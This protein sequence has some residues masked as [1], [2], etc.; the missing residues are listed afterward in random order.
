MENTGGVHQWKTLPCGYNPSKL[1]PSK[2]FF[3]KQTS[4]SNLENFSFSPFSPVDHGL[5]VNPLHISRSQIPEVATPTEIISSPSHSVFTNNI[6][7]SPYSACYINGA[8]LNIRSLNTLK[9]KFLFDTIA[10]SSL[11]FFALTEL[12]FNNSSTPIAN[13]STPSNYSFLFATRPTNN[14]GGV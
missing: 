11:H 5:L 4:L 13:L 10:N 7:D 3:I 12:W 8:L 9:A 1:I 2:F 14:R 6:N